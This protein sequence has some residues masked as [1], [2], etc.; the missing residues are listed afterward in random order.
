M[1]YSTFKEV[2]FN[3]YCPKCQYD[4]KLEEDDPCFECLEVPARAD[5]HKPVN[6]KEK[7]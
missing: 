2:D 1:Y 6:F 3:K 4:K 7:E 5:S